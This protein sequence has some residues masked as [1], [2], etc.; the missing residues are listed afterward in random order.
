MPTHIKI[1]FFGRNIIGMNNRNV[2]NLIARIVSMALQLVVTWVITKILVEAIGSEA[3][4]YFQMSNDFVN[5]ATILS[6]ALNSMGSRFITMAY[7]QKDSREL[8]RYYNSLLYGD[9]LLAVAMAIPL[10]IICLNLNQFITISDEYVSDVKVLFGVM[11]LNFCVNIF[12]TVFST[13]T[14]IKNRIDLDSYRII[15]CYL[16]K[17]VVIYI[18]FKFLPAHVYYVAVGTLA[19]TI[20]MIVRNAH[21]TKLLVPEA[22]LFKREYLDFKCIKEL[23]ASGAWNSVTRISSVLLGGLDLLIANQLVGSTA[24]GVLSIAKTIPKYFLSGMSTVASVFA[25]SLLINYAKK[26]TEKTVRT[27]YDSVKVNSFFCGIVV[28]ILCVLGRRIFILWTPSQDAGILLE[29][30]IISIVGMMLLMPLEIIWTVFTATNKLKISSIYL[31]AESIV[32][33]GIEFLLLSMVDNTVRKLIIIAGTS[34]IMEIIRSLT[35][36]PLVGAHLLKVSYITFYKPLIR[37]VI[38][39]SVTI[40]VSILIN[41]MIAIEGWVGFGISAIAIAIV[42]ACLSW[43]IVFN[44]EEKARIKSMVLKR[45]RR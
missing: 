36:M 41:N 25:P 11:F 33:I 7:Y 10:F 38:N 1:M 39:Y 37:V 31:L 3:N 27:V 4:G 26:D 43:C 12:G 42:S 40:A 15:E 5:Y 8:N 2:K 34:T 30:A 21:Y 22:K 24:M 29:L 16:I 44:R 18:L 17:L 9:I 14:F 20:I 35:F 45:I 6:I 28:T 19:G 23:T 13:A 32:T